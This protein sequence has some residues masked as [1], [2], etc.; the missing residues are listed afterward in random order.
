MPEKTLLQISA[1]RAEQ[2]KAEV[3]SKV[4]CLCWSPHHHK[5]PAWTLSFKVVTS[6]VSSAVAT[7]TTVFF[8]TQGRQSLKSLL[9]TANYDVLLFQ[10]R[11]EATEIICFSKQS[12][13]AHSWLRDDIFKQNHF[14]LHEDRLVPQK[15][16]ILLVG[17]LQRERAARVVQSAEAEQG[18]GSALLNAHKFGNT[19]IVFGIKTTISPFP[20][21]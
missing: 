17:S 14:H 11:L 20:K 12:V 7:C 1:V 16:Q 8:L 21:M 4:L 13:G 19:G 2:S 10:K 6:E 18:Q 3:C 5:R 9:I 15:Q